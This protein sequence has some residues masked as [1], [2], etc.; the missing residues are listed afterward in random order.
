MQLT[1]LV[2]AFQMLT[3]LSLDPEAMEALS[4]DHATANTL[5]TWP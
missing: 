1:F 5:S 4:G 2:S 3:V